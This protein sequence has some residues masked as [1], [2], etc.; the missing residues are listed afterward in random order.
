MHLFKKLTF[1]TGRQHYYCMNYFVDEAALE[2]NNK[3]IFTAMEVKTLLPAA[4]PELMDQ[5]FIKMTGPTGF[6]PSLP[7]GGNG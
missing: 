5:F 7:I 6:F 2:V 1:L 4:G 3:N